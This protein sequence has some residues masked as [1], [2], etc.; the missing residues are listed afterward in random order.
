MPPATP[1]PILCQQ[2]SFIK[3]ASQVDQCPPDQG[4]EVAFA[5]RSNA[6]KSSALNTLTHAR[7]ARTSKTPGRTQLI[8]FFALDDTHRLV[9]LPGYGYAKVPLEL[10]EHWKK[11]LDAYL[12][13]RDSLAGVVLVMDIRHPLSAFDRMM[14]D[15]ANVAGLPAHIL[16]SKTDKL[17]FGAAKGVLL[18]VQST[19]RKEFGNR[20]S[21]QLFSSPKRQGIDEAHAV[22]ESWLYPA[23]DTEQDEDQPAATE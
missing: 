15:W 2:A 17:S 8:N 12:T 13:Q 14:L 5:G 19:V 20:A 22:L 3:S 23:E 1:L 16:L 6:G 11:H 7:L 18:K 10:K 9:D 21:V 4:Y